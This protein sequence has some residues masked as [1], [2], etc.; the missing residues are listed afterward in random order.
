MLIAKHKFG[1]TT[2][3]QDIIRWPPFLF[4]FRLLWD[5]A[6]HGLCWF[7]CTC[8][9]MRDLAKLFI[10]TSFRSQVLHFFFIH[11]QKFLWSL[12][13]PVDFGTYALSILLIPHFRF[14]Y[15]VALSQCPILH[16][17]GH[18]RISSSLMSFCHLMLGIL[19]LMPLLLCLYLL[20]VGTADMCLL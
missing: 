8:C 15:F 10:S 6:L 4:H 1:A 3:Q 11:K 5:R 14:M 2:E 16:V 19:L 17:P 18:L 7:C 20:F 13:L 9:R 12:Q